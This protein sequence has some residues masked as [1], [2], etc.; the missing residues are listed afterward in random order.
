MKTRS[1][2]FKFPGQSLRCAIAILCAASLVS[3]P[4]VT[5]GQAAQD[6]V[7]TPTITNEVPKITNDQLDSLVAPIALYPD[8]LLSQTLVASTYPLELIQLQ[9]WLERNKNLKDKALADAVQKQPWDPSVQALAAFPSVVERSAGN[10]QWTT[11]L[12]NAFLAQQSDV[13]DAV[14]RMRVKAKDTGNLKSGAEQIV[15]T[16]AVEGGKEV[17]VI[18]PASPKV[19]YVPTYDFVVVY[20]APVYPYPRYYY[21]GY[22]PGRALA[23]GVGLALGASWGGSWG[24]HC[25][26]GRKNTVVINNKNTYVNNSS[27]TTNVNASRTNINAGN[28]NI[29]AG[30]TNIGNQVGGNNTW[31]HNPQHRGGA[32]YGDKSTADKF[33]GRTPG[34]KPGGAG[35]RPVGVGGIGDAGS[36]PGGVGGIGD[37]GNKAGGAG[38]NRP[39][40]MPANRPSGGSKIGNRSVSPGAGFGASMSAFGGGGCS[41]GSSRASSA[42]GSRSMGGAGLD[43]DRGG[44]GGTARGGKRR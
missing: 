14:Q 35:S 22:V 17:I 3:V 20:G 30:N 11:E 18:Q 27:R 19:V 6:P 4:P 32:P 34:Q 21:P 2:T 5:L 28:S 37:A 36:K 40:T 29:K 26:W 24:Y 7:T 38:P 1:T 41:G 39:S 9:Q 33:G 16:R 44:A 13:M 25:G 15:E 23:F 43:R 8:P 10:I 31:R 12:G 42:R